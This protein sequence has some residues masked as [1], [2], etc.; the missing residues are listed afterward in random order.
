MSLDAFLN[1][2]L[3]YAER[4]VIAFNEQTELFK[5]KTSIELDDKGKVK[6]DAT[7][8]M[9]TR[10]EKVGLTPNIPVGNHTTLSARRHQLYFGITPRGNVRDFNMSKTQTADTGDT[11]CYYLPY[12]QNAAVSMKLGSDCDYFFTSSLSGCSVQV[13][14]NHDHPTVTHANAGDQFVDL[15]GREIERLEAAGYDA[16]TAGQ[17]ANRSVNARVDTIIAAMLPNPG[18]RRPRL[19]KK[20]DY[21]KVAESRTQKRRAKALYLRDQT[22]AGEDGYRLTDYALDLARGRPTLGAAVFGLRNH[23]GAAGWTIYYQASVGVL[24]EFSKKKGL[25]FKK[26]VTRV[27]QRDEAV[28]GGVRKLFP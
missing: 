12:K 11:R 10:V 5:G 20:S 14:G 23:N 28:V 1:D 24:P 3:S 19:L 6:T 16:D 22:D 15:F 9:L 18:S 26:T 27:G 13:F 8:R 17:M 21:L 2:P 25:I 4:Y 7:G